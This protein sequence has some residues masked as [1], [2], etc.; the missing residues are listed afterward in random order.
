MA[1]RVLVG[2]V[3]AWRLADWPTRRSPPSVKATM[4]GVVRAPSA[5]SMTRTS[6]PSRMAT[7]ELVVPRSIPMTLLMFAPF[8]GQRWPEAPAPS[9]QRLIA[10]DVWDRPDRNKGK[11]Q[12]FRSGVSQFQVSRFPDRAQPCPGPA[13]SGAGALATTTMAGRSRRPCSVQPCDHAW[14]TVPGG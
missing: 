14:T 2:L 3:T 8:S 12:I 5:F 9:L 10:V 6:L 1:Y 11:R 7:Q 13:S 4:L